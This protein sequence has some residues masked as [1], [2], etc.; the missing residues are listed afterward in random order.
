[1][2]GVKDVKGKSGNYARARACA[3]AYARTGPRAYL[4]ARIAVIFPLHI[5]HTLHNF[6]ENK[7]LIDASAL[8]SALHSLHGNGGR[9]GAFPVGAF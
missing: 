2:K 3:P 7:E 1:M 9:A 4:R 6:H 5:L 8:H